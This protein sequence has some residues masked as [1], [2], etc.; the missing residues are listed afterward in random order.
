MK[1]VQRVKRLVE[2]TETLRRECESVR[3]EVER[4]RMELIEWEILHR[5]AKQQSGWN[6]GS[7]SGV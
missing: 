2:E 4:V 6:D 1:L 3:L 5:L 7:T